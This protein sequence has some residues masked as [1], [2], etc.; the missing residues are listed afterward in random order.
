M[1]VCLLTFSCPCFNGTFSAQLAS[2]CSYAAEHLTFGVVSYQDCFDLIVLLQGERLTL[3]A[4]ESARC[5]VKIQYRA[6]L[7]ELPVSRLLYLH[8][9]SI[10]TIESPFFCFPTKNTAGEQLVGTTSHGSANVCPLRSRVNQYV[11]VAC[12]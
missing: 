2:N 9:R 8:H 11:I 12:A 6:V 7:Q 5:I 10:Y 3:H 1:G 4:A